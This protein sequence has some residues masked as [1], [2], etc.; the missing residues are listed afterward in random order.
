VKD[1]DDLETITSHSVGDHV[2]RARHDEFPSA[3]DAAGTTEIGQFSKALDSGEQSASDSIGGVRIV[4]RDIRAEVSQWS[5]ARGDQ[6]IVTREAP[7]VHACDPTNEATSPRPR[8]E[9]SG[10]HRAP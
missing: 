2:P 8:A 6:T 10:P 5:M 3:G 9:H 7:F 4:V 1:G